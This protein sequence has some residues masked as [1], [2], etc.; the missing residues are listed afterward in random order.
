MAMSKGSANV[1]ELGDAPDVRFPRSDDEV[2]QAIK[3]ALV[4][5]KSVFFKA[6]NQPAAKTDVS[7]DATGGM[8][9]N[10]NA[11]YKI[12]SSLPMDAASDV[13]V[14]EAAAKNK[15]IAK[16]L[17]KHQL[18]LPL[19]SD[20]EQS[21]VSGLLRNRPTCLMRTLGPL[22]DYVTRISVVTP[23]AEK[24]SI[25]YADYDPESNAVITEVTF[26]AGEANKLW[27][28]GTTFLYPGKEKFASLAR[29]LFLKSAEQ[30]PKSTDLVLD[31]FSGRY[32]F[33]SVRILAFGF[34]EAEK[35][36]VEKLVNNAF[37]RLDLKFKLKLNPENEIHYSEII[38]SILDTGFGI[39]NDPQIETKRYLDDAVG[40]G[41]N[42]MEFI[43]RVSEEVDQG[44]GFKSDRT[45]K[46]DKNLRLICRLQLNRENQLVSSGKL[47]SFANPEDSVPFRYPNRTRQ[48]NEQKNEDFKCDIYDK[49]DLL[50]ELKSNFKGDIYDK[51]DD[52]LYELK[53]KQYATTSYPADQMLPFLVAYPAD[54]SDIQA[55]IK[56]AKA[57]QKKIVAR[58][59]GHQYCGKSS[60]NVSTIVLDMQNFS[61]FEISEDIANV[62]PAICL[63]TFSSE[64]KK[65][66]MTVPHGE[67]PMVCIGGHAQ[68]GGYGHLMR[69]HGLLLDHVMAFTIVLADGSERR[70]QRQNDSSNPDNDEL[71]WGV[72]GGN[73]GSFGIVT[74]YEIKCIKDDNKSYGCKIDLWYEKELYLTLMKE[75]QKWTI[76]VEE[77]VL[78]GN[79]DFMMT[80]E[81][82][83]NLLPRRPLIKVELV[84]TDKHDLKGMAVL[85]S[86]KNA[87]N[88]I[89]ALTSYT[90]VEGDKP[91]SELSDSFVRRYP[92]TTWCGREFKY[93]YKKRVNV[94]TKSLTDDFIK[95][96]VDLL[97]K[98]VMQTEGVYLVFQMVI[99]GGELKYSKHR[100][101][102]SIPRR[103][104]VYCLIFDLFYEEGFISVAINLQDELQGIVDTYFSP[105]QEQRLF[106]GSFGD[107]TDIKNPNNL[108]R[109]YYYDDPDS[110]KKLQNLKKKVDAGDLFHTS[111]T[112]KP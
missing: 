53:S 54:L 45:G 6:G 34:L 38:Q 37:D 57:N 101:E 13:I 5:K 61:R 80:V 44:I 52:L 15:D 19:G 73:A 62:G 27:M 10:I 30:I 2:V 69:S 23:N 106:W 88:T 103:D 102:T 87:C 92:L 65:K 22:S 105:G 33:P 3:D 78:P 24:K 4:L 14:A 86:V 31:A 39:P 49:S 107:D 28:F 71:F 83:Y 21:I 25:L 70:V 90:L 8:V 32:D 42:Q 47:Y 111:L 48:K 104:F 29:A 79:I 95:N 43:Q 60:G 63:S 12:N 51:S 16:Y 74:N 89:H 91:L 67:C 9:I 100:P 110:Y 85:N 75:V 96:F 72:L 1:E 108:V 17:A 20:P 76:G 59:G 112:V 35:G 66:Q 94:T 26:K 82:S 93:P 97:D 50:Y 77:G 109:N 7:V 84:S 55:A 40:Q 56:F 46:I 81:S 41:M 36:I 68:T 99:G 11:L 18:A 58:S 64:L 98:V